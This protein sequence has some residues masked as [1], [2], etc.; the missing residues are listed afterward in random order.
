MI[1]IVSEKAIAGQRISS[2]LAKKDV[3]T[4]TEGG[5]R[6]FLFEKDGQQYVTV[7]LRGHVVDVDFPKKYNYWIGTDLRKLAV[8]EIEY[9]ENEKPILDFLR[10]TAKDTEDVIIAT[11]NDREGESIG[12]E[13]INAILEGNSKVKIKRALFSALTPKDIETAFSSLDDINKNLADSADS[14]REIDLV[15]GA[16][17]TR[18]LSIVSGRLGKE[19]LSMGR[20]QGPT[21]AIIVNREK[22][23]LAFNP[24]DYWELLA[25]FSKGENKFEA[26]HKNGKF[27]DKAEADKAFVAKEPPLGKVSKVVKKK[28]ILKKPLPFNTTSFLGAATSIGFTAGKAM[29]L[30]ES[31]YQSGF[32]SYPRTDNEAY[33]PTIDLKAILLFLE[34]FYLQ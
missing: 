29:R 7:P 17:L 15:W 6:F 22:E 16:V 28:R 27:W 26:N 23:R 12:F 10:K 9:L 1:L 31:L 4:S 25:T 11:D 2:L 3:A 21:L 24:K 19:F 8:A 33:S 32:I 20:V 14:R 5:V 30:A 18:F 34:M 13:A